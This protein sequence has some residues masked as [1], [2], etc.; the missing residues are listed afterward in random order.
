[1][2]TIKRTQAELDA[3]FERLEREYMRLNERQQRYAVR[4]I[5]RIRSEI[6]EFLAEYA[7]DDG[8]IARRRLSRVLRDLDEIERSLREQGEIVMNRIIEETSEWTT[9]AVT[10]AA[11]ISLSN[12]Q[13]DRVN[14]HVVRY[15]V[16]RFGDDGL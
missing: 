16:K 13:F 9:N 1:M 3:I 12:A 7:E 10:N 5:G 4:E 8:I 6:A 15:V 14:E 2:A 11:G